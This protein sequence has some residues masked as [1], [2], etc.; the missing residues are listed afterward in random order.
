MLIRFWFKHVWFK[1][2]GFHSVEMLEILLLF[3]LA[4]ELYI[5]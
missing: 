1:F 2:A 4:S 5:S 3:K